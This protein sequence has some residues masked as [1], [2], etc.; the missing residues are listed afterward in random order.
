MTTHVTGTARPSASSAVPRP[1]VPPGTTDH[2]VSAH[3]IVDY[4]RPKDGL[5]EITGTPAELRQAAHLLANGHGPVAVDAERAS[6]F[7]LPHPTP[8]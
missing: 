3:D 2:P 7:R 6:G 5:P 4:P 1:A 8:P